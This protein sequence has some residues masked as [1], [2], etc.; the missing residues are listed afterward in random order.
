MECNKDT[1]TKPRERLAWMAVDV[2]SDIQHS[3]RIIG[4]KPISRSLFLLMTRIHDAILDSFAVE[5]F[6]RPGF[7][8]QQHNARWDLKGNH[9]GVLPRLPDDCCLVL[10]PSPENGGRTISTTQTNPQIPVRRARLQYQQ[11]AMVHDRY[12]PKSTL[13]E[14]SKIGW[15]SRWLLPTTCTLS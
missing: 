2:L 3:F 11:L 1:G 15:A 8:S 6:V 13:V 5:A 14:N 4:E 9:N 7:Q 12:R 10:L